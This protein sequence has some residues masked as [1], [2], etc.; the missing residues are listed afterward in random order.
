MLKLTLL[1]IF[2]FFSMYSWKRLHEKI[3]K[4][5]ILDSL[6]SRFLNVV[7]YFILPKTCIAVW[8]FTDWHFTLLQR[9]A[10][11]VNKESI[12]MYIYICMYVYIYMY[13][14][15]YGSGTSVETFMFYFYQNAVILTV[16]NPYLLN[17]PIFE[18]FTIFTL[19]VTVNNVPIP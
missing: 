9:H 19:L 3:A 11:R 6:L 10:G 12:Y 7:V 5:L 15:L 16:S 1:T 2:N 14:Y 17:W 18:T 4:I 13:M 8:W